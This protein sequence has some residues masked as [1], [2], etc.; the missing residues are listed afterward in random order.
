M[1]AYIATTTQRDK[2]IAITDPVQGAYRFYMWIY[3]ANI[4]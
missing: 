2:E 1:A 3:I 4:I